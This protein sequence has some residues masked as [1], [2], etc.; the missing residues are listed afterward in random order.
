[1]AGMLDGLRFEIL[2]AS[3]SSLGREWRRVDAEPDP[4]NRIYYIES[5]AASATHSGKRRKLL[6]GSLHLIP[7]NAP[8]AFA[9][10]SRFCVCWTHFRALSQEGFDVAPHLGCALDLELAP[11]EEAEVAAQFAVLR[12]AC[13]GSL[14]GSFRALSALLALFAR[15]LDGVSERDALWRVGSLAR[16]RKAF[17]LMDAAPSAPPSVEALAAELK[18]APASFSR[19]F[20]RRFGLA[21]ARFLMARRLELSKSLLD[22]GLALGEIALKLGFSDAFHFSKAFKSRYG[23]SPSQYRRGLA[24]ETP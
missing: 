19:L 8:V 9:C 11:G 20:K 13:G 1:M 5:G 4:F 23:S 15:F 14:G 7:T 10:Q 18:M 16:F 12:A 17:E 22:D 2:T 24:L 3:R 21:P 6:P